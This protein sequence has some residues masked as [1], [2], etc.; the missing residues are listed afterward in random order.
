MSEL[1]KSLGKYYN[2]LN[3]YQSDDGTGL[4]RPNDSQVTGGPYVDLDWFSQLLDRLGA[5]SAVLGLC[6]ALV[7][8]SFLLSCH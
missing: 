3:P 7:D 2:P 8:F 1:G 4:Q 6:L 5:G